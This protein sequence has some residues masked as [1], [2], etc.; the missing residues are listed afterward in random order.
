MTTKPKS[1]TLCTVGATAMVDVSPIEL[2]LEIDH[3]P[4]M[5][6]LSF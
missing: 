1:P 4:N 2:G 6:S 3:G 5:R